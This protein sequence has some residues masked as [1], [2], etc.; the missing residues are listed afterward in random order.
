[1]LSARRATMN[2]TK[3]GGLWENR[4]HGNNALDSI[5]ITSR[6]IL[7]VSVIL[8]IWQL[9]STYFHRSVI[10]GIQALTCINCH[11]H[12]TTV[13]GTNMTKN[14]PQI[15][16]TNS[17]LTKSQ[18]GTTRNMTHRW[19]LT[20]RV[21]TSSTFICV[22]SSVYGFTVIRIRIMST[23]L[24]WG[25]IPTSD[26]RFLAS[27]YPKMRSQLLDCEMTPRG[28]SHFVAAGLN[29]W[30]ELEI[31]QRQRLNIDSKGFTR[32]FA[33]AKNRDHLIVNNV[34]VFL[35]EHLC[36]NLSVRLSSGMP[37]WAS[38]HHYFS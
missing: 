37:W 9:M 18:P 22:R 12:L 26:R 24:M 8:S 32:Y 11:T 28:W 15:A 5:S 25:D 29:F 2:L 38:H 27:L 6:W 21:S 23:K 16:L 17:C 36:R 13:S 33:G 7:C 19:I 3:C 14:T 10:H 35:S 4:G 20:G 31:L 34:N 30:E 1:M